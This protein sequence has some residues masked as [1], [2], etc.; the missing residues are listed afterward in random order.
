[1]TAG[2]VYLIGA[3]PG[4]PGLVTLKAVQCLNRADVVVYDY[5]AN[6]AILEHAAKDAELIYAGK[7]GGCH[8]MPQDEINN[9]LVEKALQGKTVA[10]LKGGDPFIFG[11]GGEEASHL[12]QNNVPFEVVPGVT[13][14]VAAPAYAGIPLTDRRYTT[15]VSLI[16]GHEDPTKE[17]SSLDWK[18]IASNMGTLVFFMGV[19]NLPGIVENLVKNDRSEDTP[20]AIIQQGSSPLQKTVTGTLK[21]IV[22]VA[23]EAGIKPPSIIL[24]GDVVRLR[25]ELNWYETKPLF[26]RTIIVT[27]ARQQASPFLARL[28]ELG[29]NAVAFPAIETVPPESWEP[30]DRAIDVLT[31]YQWVIFTSVNGVN[32]FNERLQKKGLDARALSG[33]K[34]AAIGPATAERL[35]AMGIKA[36]FVP[37]E[38]RAEAVIEGL[39]GTAGPGTRILLARAKEARDVLPEELRKE[40]ATVDIVPA[41]ETVLPS[42]RVKKVEKMLAE[43]AVDIITF[44]SS[45]TVTN[46]AR[47]FPDRDVASLL[48]DVQVAC[49][50]PIT[51]KTA[52]K[53]GLAVHIQPE[54]YTIDSLVDAIVS[55]VE[56]MKR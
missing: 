24:V 35:L 56:N 22:D 4:D 9:L 20:V 37:S 33:I 29:A 10:R 42:H 38:Y 47:M 48:K 25:P 17:E 44:T 39:K 13:S 53:M 40:G 45:S 52:Q 23:R 31:A 12:F 5:L 36:D 46:F 51:A 43:G 28:V 16:T 14:A 55:H 3:G 15:S 49:I 26:G 21:T 18:N 19:K 11:R 32:Y 27:R 34:V 7:M 50:G 30:L 1:M 2:T 54:H 41:Y 8:A 6:E